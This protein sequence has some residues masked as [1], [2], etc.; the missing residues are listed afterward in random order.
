M[1]IETESEMKKGYKNIFLCF[2]E[3]IWRAAHQEK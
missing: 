1:K 2:A 3:P